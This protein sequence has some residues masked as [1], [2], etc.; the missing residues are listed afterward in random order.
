MAR[1]TAGRFLAAFLI[2]CITHLGML[3]SVHAAAVDTQ[4][5]LQ[6]ED[7]DAAVSA[8]QAKLGRA[9]VRQA[10]TDLGV[11]PD[12]AQQ[13][14]AALTDAEIAKLQADLDRLPAGGDGGWILLAIVLGILIYLFATGKLQYR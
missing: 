2:L 7:R 9:D 5:V 10:L 12:T 4:T 8:V 3:Q 6:L 13:R 11:D 14:V 1:T